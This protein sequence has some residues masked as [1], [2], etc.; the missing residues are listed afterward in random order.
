V[1][2]LDEVEAGD[3]EDELDDIGLQLELESSA[4]LP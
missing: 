2:L 1:W 3:D 4:A